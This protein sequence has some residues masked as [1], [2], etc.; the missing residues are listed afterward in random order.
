MPHAVVARRGRRSPRW[1]PRQVFP[2][3]CSR[4]VLESVV[5]R[6]AVIAVVPRHLQRRAT[7]EQADQ[8]LA[9]PADEGHEG[10]D[11]PSGDTAGAFMPEKSVSRWNSTRRPATAVRCVGLASPGLPVTGV[12][13]SSRASPISWS[14]RRRSFSRH[15]QQSSKGGRSLDR[16]RVPIG[17]LRMMNASVSVTSSPANARACPSASRRGRTR[18]PICRRVCPPACHV[19]VPTLRPRRP[20][21]HTNA[22]SSPAS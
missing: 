7:G 9:P 19:P 4:S 8:N 18:M 21:N 22:S 6:G 1:F 15:R 16:Q 14:R 17:L 5:H 11:L 13:I 10:D 20:E 2:T 12:S 3:A